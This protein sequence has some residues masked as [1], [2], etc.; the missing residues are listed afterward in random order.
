MQCE[1][2]SRRGSRQ[3]ELPDSSGYPNLRFAKLCHLT[4]AN[5]VYFREEE[6][7][8]RLRGCLLQTRPLIFSG[9]SARIDAALPG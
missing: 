3:H 5:Q 6:A 9:S 8:G 4:S 7:P 1:P 2:P